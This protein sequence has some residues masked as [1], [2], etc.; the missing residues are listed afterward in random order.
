M[1]I[2]VGVGLSV[3]SACD[4]SG[5]R[6]RGGDVLRNRFDLQTLPLISYPPDNQP[7]Q[8]RIALGRLLFFD[9]ILAGEMDVSCGTCHHPSFAFADSRQFGAGVSGSGLG[10]TRI[11]STS[12]MTGDPVHL[13]PRN[14]PTVFNAAFNGDSTGAPSHLGLMFWDGRRNGIEA[15]ASLPIASRVEMRGDAYPGTDLE[16]EDVALDSVLH[17]LREIPEY[18]TR[19]QMAFPVEAVSI[20]PMTPEMII[21]SST[22]A[23]AIASYVRELVTRNSAY[24]R[25]VNG[26]D[27]AL[28]AQQKHG[29]ELFFTKAKCSSCHS[30]PMFSD[31]SFIVQGVP[32]EGTGKETLP[33]DDLGRAEETQL[34]TDMYAFKT[35]SLRNVELTAPY[36][37]DGVFESLE[38]VLRFYN[39]G[40]HPRHTQVTDGM[41]APIL[42]DSLHLTIEEIEA[43]IAFMRS[44]TDPGTALPPFLTTVP[45]S[46]PSGLMPVF[47]V[48]GPGT[49]IATR[50][51]DYRPDAN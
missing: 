21:D 22:Y 6:P 2:V 9:P 45:E 13:E 23:R 31:F 43:I 40:A 34:P 39:D 51:R 24:D 33:G 32:Q 25:Y 30:G 4:G 27:D 49:G 5:I 41:L 35:P 50:V 38:E 48:E 12:A 7:R 29:L 15:L 36:M 20:D 26:D 1:P 28:S 47:G 19:F 46:V 37:H 10:P 42:V 3:L 14:T 17:R 18:V 8:E 11:M 44:L 16:A